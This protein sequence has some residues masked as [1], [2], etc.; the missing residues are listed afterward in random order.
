MASRKSTKAPEVV[1][2][3]SQLR[4]LL[5]P[6]I[7]HAGRDETLPLLT[8]VL[9]QTAGGY[10]TAVATDRYSIGMQ[11]VKPADAPPAGLS[12]LIRARSARVLLAVF[13]P[14]RHVDPDVRLTFGKDSLS[15]SS[16]GEMPG[17]GDMVPSMVVGLIEGEYPALGRLLAPVIAGTGEMPS[18]VALNAEYLKRLAV[19]QEHAHAQPMRLVF[20]HPQKPVGV[21]IGDDF[22]GAVQP[23]RPTGDARESTPW[24][25]L[26]ITQA[27]E[28]A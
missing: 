5:A 7:P 9:I 11:R 10:V 17:L 25:D 12:A 8:G 28:A 22:I 14:S 23:A 15:V 26:L 24:D 20:T 16:A 13:K 21:L 1:L 4:T 18:G 27:K 3:A 2:K 19:A 6:V